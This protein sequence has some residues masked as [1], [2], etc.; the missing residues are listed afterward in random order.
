MP[1]CASHFTQCLKFMAHFIQAYE[2]FAT[3]SAFQMPLVCQTGYR[4]LPYT[5]IFFFLILGEAHYKLC[6]PL[7]RYHRN[8]VERTFNTIQSINQ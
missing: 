5:S 4:I 8:I 7:S 1:E 3:C 6:F 2:V